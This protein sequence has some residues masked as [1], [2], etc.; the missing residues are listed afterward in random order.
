[1]KF[2][3]LFKLH[4]PIKFQILIYNSNNCIIIYYNI[5]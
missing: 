2:Y 1:M 3:K 4:A 5:E